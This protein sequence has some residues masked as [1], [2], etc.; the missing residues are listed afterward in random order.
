[1]YIFLLYFSLKI[2]SSHLG[3]VLCNVR[4]ALVVYLLG[5]LVCSFVSHV[6]SKQTPCES[7][8]RLES[9][10]SSDTHHGPFR[11]LLSGPFSTINF[12]FKFPGPYPFV[13]SSV[14][15]PA[16]I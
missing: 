12:P 11:L 7:F 5:S 14:I 13:I 1:M 15:G 16:K 10:K 4:Y 9:V 8:L 3:F 6:L 2:L